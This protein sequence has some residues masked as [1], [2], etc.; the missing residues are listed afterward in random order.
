MIRNI[1]ILGAGTMGI[2]I[3]RVFADHGYSTSLYEPREDLAVVEEK[4]LLLGR[5]TTSTMRAQEH[6]SNSSPILLF[7]ELE[8]AVTNADFILEAVPEQLEIKRDV[9]RQLARSI[10]KDTIVASNTSTFPL[11]TLAENQP[12]RDNMIIAHFFHPAH[13]IP[14]VEIVGLPSTSPAILDEIVTLMRTCDKTPVVLKRDIPGFIANRLQA[15]LIRE[16]CYLL[17]NGVA[18][19]DQID[20]VVKE[21]LGLRWAFKGPFEVA[22]LGGLDIWMKVTG[23]L[24]SQLS[25]SQDAPE[26]MAAKVAN[27]KLGVKSGS[28][29][30]DYKDPIGTTRE[31]QHYLKQLAA[32]KKN[33]EG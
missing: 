26:S 23:H 5:S 11:E 33:S 19:A 18:D 15:A 22:D 30:Y 7:N 2:A 28:G 31:L 21:A 4:L 8:Q 16:A 3:A 25:T 24:F 6:T 32:L 14:L 12:F 29:Y 20:T 13:L 10:K 27:G 17:E 9:Y 1:T